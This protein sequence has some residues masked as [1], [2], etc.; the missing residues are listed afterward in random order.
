MYFIIA[1]LLSSSLYAQNNLHESPKWIKLLHYKKNLFGRYVSQADSRSFFL[2]ANGKFDAK[3]ELE[4]SIEIFGSEAK[5]GNDH[6]ICKFPLRYKWLNK[7]LGNPWKADFSGCTTYIDFF[8]KLAARRASIIFSSYYLSSPNSAFG[9]TL[10]RLSRFD[11]KNETEMLDYGINYAAQSKEPN[12][13]LYI[14]KGIF[15]GFIGEFAAIPYYYKIREYTNIEFRDLWSYDLKLSTMEVLEMVDHIWELGNTHFDY[16][17]F[18]ENCSYHLLSIVEVARPTV[19]L[20]DTYSLYT[21]PADT[22]RLL[23]Q[24]GLIEE[25]KRRESTY[26]KLTRLSEDLSNKEL[27]TAKE[28]SDH[29]SKLN[30]LLA[31][32][33]DKKKAQILDV[34]IE[35]FDYFNFEKILADDQKAK[36]LKFPILS[37]RAVNPVVSEDTYDAKKL[38]KD[39]P[40]KGHSSTRLTLAENYWDKVGKST[41]FEYRSALHDILDPPAGAL[42]QSQLE[43]GRFSFEVREQNYED[44]KLILDQ[45]AVFSIRNLA[46]QNFWTSPMSWE[47]ETGVKQLK[48]SM[49]FDCPAGY[50]SGSIGNSISLS[51]ERVLMSLLMNAEADVQSQFANNYRVGLGPKFF[52]RVKFSDKW[53]TGINSWYHFNTYEHDKLFQDYEWWSELELRHH[54][55]DRIS[56]KVSGGGVERE[57]IW[58]GFGEFGL[59]YFYE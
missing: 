4:K 22:V 58:Q 13:L 52:T 20:T 21:I 39:S 7:E 44:P 35:A 25:G 42:K 48:R 17:Y 12:P 14:V 19:N 30:E 27:Q 32:M 45:V 57:R 1:L 31:G 34:S 47:L 23:D 53:I 3:G 54:L 5:P 43:M 10:L 51:N 46:E 6:A 8:S 15:G 41:R 18:H 36:E 11:D 56:L 37:A 49:C 33:D 38:Q 40:A 28:I 16:F 55:T 50:V 24:E 2:S 9:H 29:P 59:Q 26:S